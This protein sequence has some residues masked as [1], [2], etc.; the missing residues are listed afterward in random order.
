MTIDIHPSPALPVD[1][2]SAWAKPTLSNTKGGKL[3]RPTHPDLFKVEFTFSG[4][5]GVAGADGAVAGEESFS[6]RLVAARV[7]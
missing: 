6:S 7:S 4:V 1:P 2:P 5:A 3:Y